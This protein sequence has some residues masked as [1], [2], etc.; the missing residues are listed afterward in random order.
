M[1]YKVAGDHTQR[2]HA[3][4]LVRT[5]GLA[6]YHHRAQIGCAAQL[7]LHLGV[8]AQQLLRGSIAVAVGQQLLVPG[9]CHPN[10]LTGLL[11]AVNRIA[12]VAGLAAQIGLAHPGSPALRRTVQEQLIAAGTVMPVIGIGVIR[13]GP[14]GAAEVSV[15]HNIHIASIRLAKLLQ[16]LG[17]LLR[18]SP[19]E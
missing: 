3:I 4:Q 18:A 7:F 10:Q 14:G 16:P 11:I 19:L 6:V 2:G 9:D 8:A 15:A 1:Y 17:G 5:D 12:A 13:N